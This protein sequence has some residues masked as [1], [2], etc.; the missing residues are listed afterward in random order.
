MFHTAICILC[1]T[2]W[3]VFVLPVGILITAAVLQIVLCCQLLL[4]LTLLK[5]KLKVC[6]VVMKILGSDTMGSHVEG[7][8]I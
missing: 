3:A 2:L 4:Q 7:Q 8:G 6:A 5:D 1:A